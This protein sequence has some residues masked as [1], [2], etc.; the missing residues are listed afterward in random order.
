MNRFFVECLGCQVLQ[1]TKLIMWGLYKY[2]GWL[3]LRN[4][5]CPYAPNPSHK[6]AMFL[7][8]NWNISNI[9]LPI[10]YW[11]T[12]ILLPILY[13]ITVVLLQTIKN[14][15]PYHRDI[16]TFRKMVKMSQISLHYFYHKIHHFTTIK[17]LMKKRRRTF[18]RVSV[19]YAE[20]H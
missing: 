8:V 19:Q 4:A 13:W 10:L 3:S 15:H 20:H 16:L 2:I 9:L 6:V 11:I 7:A 12:V 1:I 5:S 18:W 14:Y 17:H